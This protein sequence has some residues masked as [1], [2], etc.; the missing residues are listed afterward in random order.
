MQS[1]DQ[2]VKKAV[3]RPC[4]IATTNRDISPALLTAFIAIAMCGDRF[5]DQ[6]QQQALIGILAELEEEHAWPTRVTQAQLKRA[7][8]WENASCIRTI[9]DGECVC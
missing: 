8:G 3:L 1:V 2:N 4:G 9:L 7:W 5:E 6:L